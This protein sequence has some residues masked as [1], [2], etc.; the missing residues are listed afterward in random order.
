[1]ITN[2]IDTYCVE[3]DEPVRAQIIERDGALAV[4]GEVVQFDEMVP[5]CPHC[6]AEIG[7]SR[8]GQKNL[9]TAY[10]TYC[11]AHGLVYKPDIIELR[12]STGLSV[13]EFSKFLGF[14]EQT[15]A[16]YE[17]GSIP[18]EL[19]SNTIKMASNPQGAKLLLTMNG[20]N[21]S[22]SSVSKIESYIHRLETGEE[23]NTLW[24]KLYGGAQASSEPNE[25][26]GYRSIDGVRIGALVSIIADKCKDLFKT[27]LQKAMFFCDFYAFELTSL[28][29]TG[30]TYAHADYGPVMEN[31]EMHLQ[32]MKNRGIIDIVPAG[33]WGEVVVPVATFENPF[34]ESEMA[35]IS[36]VCAFVN[37]FSTS[38]EISEYSH[39]L[40]A[41]RGTRSGQKISYQACNHEVAQAVD[42]RL[43]ERTQA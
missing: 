24:M 36:N 16:R 17:S 3:C 21:M 18:D 6:G 30:M 25:F 2:Y 41:W 4:K 14:G 29:L 33:D 27:K 22:E 19:H 8:T 31:Y 42:A 11:L 5:V 26:N 28:S 20:L 32:A 34:S 23:K 43:R 39:K 10:G 37:T 15:A 9:E 13:R 38:S 12:R 1:M 35:L 7:D 40:E